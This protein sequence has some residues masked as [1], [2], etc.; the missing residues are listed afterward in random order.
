VR[1]PLELTN[2][3]VFW[4]RDRLGAGRNLRALRV[5]AGISQ[6]GLSIR[7][8][9]LRSTIGEYERAE[10]APREQ[11]IRALA[12][13]LGVIPEAFVTTESNGG[14]PVDPVIHHGA[15]GQLTT[16]D[17]GQLQCHLCGDYFDHL[18]IHAE[19][20]HGLTAR[21]YREFA[22]LHPST[23][24]VIPAIHAA[25]A[26]WSDRQARDRSLAAHTACRERKTTSPTAQQNH[27][28][29]EQLF[30][31]SQEASATANRAM[32]HART[33]AGAL[34]HPPKPETPPRTATM[35]ICRACG[36]AFTVPNGRTRVTCSN[37][38]RVAWNRMRWDRGH[39]ARA[40]WGAALR[41]CR[42]AAGLTATTL[43]AAVSTDAP[44]ICMM[45]K[46]KAG[47]TA[48]LYVRLKA[49]LPDLPERPVSVLS[50]TLN[51]DGSA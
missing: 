14:D 36:V 32:L 23:R 33:V 43:A 13:A 42:Q 35:Q 24:L 27:A 48:T 15:V 26:E 41:A 19:H 1:S 3:A 11:A 29:A 6:G 17:A 40:A 9:I 28:R 49:I 47:P 16:N 4:R 34:R 46:G 2:I 21:E 38:C 7:S 5:A 39:E 44:R 18:G 22:G 51:P 31:P 45:E 12:D 8:G 50:Y 20:Q 30:N 25:I 10:K 37:P